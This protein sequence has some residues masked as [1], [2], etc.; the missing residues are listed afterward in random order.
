[1]ID[2]YEMETA[3]AEKELVKQKKIIAKSLINSTSTKTKSTVPSSLPQ[4]QSSSTSSSL[5]NQ[6]IFPSPA[7]LPVLKKN[8]FIYFFYI[9]NLDPG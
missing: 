5:S 8:V 4:T 6:P 7:A 9:F 2:E 3:E 1:M